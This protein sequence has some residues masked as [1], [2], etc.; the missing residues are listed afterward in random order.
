MNFSGRVKKLEVLKNSLRKK[1]NALYCSFITETVAHIIRD[2]MDKTAAI[3]F[4]RG[5]AQRSV[6]LED[7]AHFVEAVERDIMSLHEGNIARHR[8]RNVEY[9]A[10]HKTWH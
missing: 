10:W 6:P 1:S 8:I 3:A 2:C 7:Q 5:Y 9:E 4:I